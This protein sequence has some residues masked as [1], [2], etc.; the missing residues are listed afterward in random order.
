MAVFLAH[1]ESAHVTAQAINVD[2]GNV[3]S[4]RP[5]FS[6]LASCNT[7][8]TI[9]RARIPELEHDVDRTP[10]LGHEPAGRYGWL[11]CLAHV[12][13]NPQ[14][15]WSYRD[16]CELHLIGAT[17]DQVFVGHY[18]G[19]FEPGQ[20]LL[21]GPG[22]P[23]QER[24]RNRIEFFV[25]SEPTPAH[26]AR[27]RGAQRRVR[28]GE[29]VA[30]LQPRHRQQLRRLREPPAHPPR[31]PVADGSRPLH[32]QRLLRRGLQQRRQPQ[33]PHPADQGHGTE[34]IAAPGR[35]ALRSGRMTFQSAGTA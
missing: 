34:G 6:H 17:R 35:S 20:R 9:P 21:A 8:M 30:L 4:C 5:E 2:G 7:P 19:H 3:M 16:E 12:V 15:R 14:L 27:A 25:L 10:M 33:S 29:F 26:F 18:I 28:F 31:L 1:A 24:T 13:P 11:R 32:P 23:L 22:L